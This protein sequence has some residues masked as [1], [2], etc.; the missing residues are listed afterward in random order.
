MSLSLSS[1]C[2]DD[3]QVTAIISVLL[4]PSAVDVC[5]K[6]TLVPSSK[7]D[8]PASIQLT[9]ARS[10][11]EERNVLHGEDFKHMAVF[12]F[13]YL[14]VICCLLKSSAPIDGL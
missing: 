12:G 4:T 1:A 14:E 13:V 6:L 9:L 2:L 7:T 5:V 8:D 3:S 11:T 10:T